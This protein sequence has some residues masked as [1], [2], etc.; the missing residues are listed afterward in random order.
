MPINRRSLF[1]LGGVGLAVGGGTGALGA[2]I[3]QNMPGITIQIRF[4]RRQWEVLVPNTDGME[5]TPPIEGFLASTQWIPL[6]DF[7]SLLDGT[8]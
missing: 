1:A 8:A 4:Y 7:L 5:N 6:V 2:E 3:Q